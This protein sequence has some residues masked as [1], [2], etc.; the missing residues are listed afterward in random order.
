MPTV[1]ALRRSRGM[2]FSDLAL[3]SGVPVRTLAEIEYGLQVLDA[4]TQS[5][6]AHA[7]GLAPE[8]L[9]G[10]VPP[11]AS[12]DPQQAVALV[13]TSMVGVAA[14]LPL[15]QGGAAQSLATSVQGMT[16]F[17]RAPQAA[18]VAAPTDVPS[19]TA[20]P[21]PTATD[22]P[23]ATAAPVTAT[24]VPRTP[25]PAFTREADGPHGC[26][27]MPAVGMHIVI[28]QPNGVGSHV[29]AA[30]MGADDLA[31]DADGDGYVEPDSTAGTTIVATLAGTARIFPDSWPGGNFVIITNADGYATAYGHLASFAIADGQQIAAG[32][33]IGTVGSTGMATGPHLHYEIRTPNGN[34]DPAPLLECAT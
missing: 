25:T 8:H 12:R 32:T 4:R 3:A 14:L 24:T 31:I 19:P 13:L 16:S 18:L 33:P 6:L 23:T 2:T 20:T 22:T 17:G 15:L 28:T 26:P 9:R 11:H 1:R 7:L 30:T 27:L 29:P 21:R 34:I 10:S 5:L